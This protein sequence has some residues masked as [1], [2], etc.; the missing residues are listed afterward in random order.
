MKTGAYGL[1]MER[2]NFS[3]LFLITVDEEGVEV[4]IGKGKLVFKHL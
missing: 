4:F 3:E 2:N 1:E